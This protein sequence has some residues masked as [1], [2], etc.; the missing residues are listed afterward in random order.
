MTGV[1]DGDGI[2][3][4]TAAADASATTTAAP[5]VVGSGDDT[6]ID[7]PGVGRAIW[8]QF[9]QEARFRSWSVARRNP[10]PPHRILHAAQVLMWH[11]NCD[12]LKP[13]PTHQSVA[14]PNLHP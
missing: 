13:N 8:R 5:N 12:L 1:E 3:G 6:L 9:H 7:W 10:T 11:A 4:S 14:Y 2:S